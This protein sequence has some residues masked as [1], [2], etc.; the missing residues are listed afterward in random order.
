MVQ[1][2]AA[3]VVVVAADVRVWAVLAW[4]AEDLL[5]VAEDRSNHMT[6]KESPFLFELN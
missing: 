2:W 4:V 3:D 6:H 5:W 1:A